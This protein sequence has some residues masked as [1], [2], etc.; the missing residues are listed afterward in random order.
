LPCGNPRSPLGI[1]GVV[2]AAGGWIG[3]AVIGIG[4]PG[5]GTG[6]DAGD[7]A[8]NGVGALSGT[9]STGAGAAAPPTMG[10]VPPTTQPARCCLI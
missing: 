3:G 10:D 7:G 2:S 5:G 9:A 8:S 4:G 6:I 1:V